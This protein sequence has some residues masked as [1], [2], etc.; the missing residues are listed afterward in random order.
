MPFS[1]WA[2]REVDLYIA[3]E[4][5]W[6]VGNLV[7]W[8]V[9]FGLESI[10]KSPW[11]SKIQGVALVDFKKGEKKE[12]PLQEARNY[13][14]HFLLAPWSWICTAVLVQWCYR[15]GV[16]ATLCFLRVVTLSM[17]TKKILNTSSLYQRKNN[18]FQVHFTIKHCK[19]SQRKNNWCHFS[20]TSRKEF[21][22]KKHQKLY[23][24][25]IFLLIVLL[26]WCLQSFWHRNIRPQS[27]AGY[28]TALF[29]NRYKH[30]FLYKYTPTGLKKQI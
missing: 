27:A 28:V 24:F 26:W 1:A 20:R 9:H 5:V 25:T 11:W 8:A 3:I 10:K 16:F 17:W 23:Y 7:S 12:L 21:F 22:G 19:A 29:C 4:L 30:T 14:E 2:A 13:F 6:A 15:A 18:W